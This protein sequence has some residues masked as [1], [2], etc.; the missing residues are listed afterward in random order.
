MY[1]R[2][3]EDIHIV[4][5]YYPPLNIGD[6]TAYKKIRMW[7]YAWHKIHWY[8]DPEINMKI[9]RFKSELHGKNIVWLIY[10]F[11]INLFIIN[12]KIFVDTYTRVRD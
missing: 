8:F 12:S 10:S 6:K 3:I 5:R 7:K 4:K 11:T 9:Y 2:A 1:F